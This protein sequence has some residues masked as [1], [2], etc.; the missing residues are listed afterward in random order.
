MAL[1]QTCIRSMDGSRSEECVEFILTR[2]RKQLWRLT[3]DLAEGKKRSGEKV[4]WLIDLIDMY[5]LLEYPVD[6]LHAVIVHGWK[7]IKVLNALSKD[8]TP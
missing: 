5:S 3:P 2:K 1:L 4:P 6:G 8:G 7:Q